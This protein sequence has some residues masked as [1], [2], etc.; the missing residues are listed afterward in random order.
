MLRILATLTSVVCIAAVV[1]LIAGVGLLWSAGRL[2][3]ETINGIADL[4]DGQEPVLPSEPEIPE[5]LAQVAKEEVIDKRA[6]SILELT[7]RERE[8]NLL[9]GLIEAEA[10]E[11]VNQRRD[12]DRAQKAFKQQ[13]EDVEA[14]LLSESAEQARGILLALPAEKAVEK[15]MT[16]EPAEAIML[17]KGVAE[18]SHAK[19]LQE[20]QSQEETVR[21]NEIF[22]AIVRGL[23]KRDVL[24]QAENTANGQ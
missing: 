3:P 20:F 11:V 15:L 1:T 10:A 12:L 5:E 22:Q 24:Q 4:L 21:G 16:L 2:T 6:M 17:M 13:L 14:E 9:K 18:K 8:L 19:I 23:P 7:A